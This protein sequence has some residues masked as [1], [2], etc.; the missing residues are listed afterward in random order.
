MK[1]VKN[2]VMYQATTR[3]YKVGDILEFGKERNYQAQR[4]FNTNYRMDGA[5]NGMAEITK[6][7]FEQYCAEHKDEL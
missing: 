7:L 5:E 4:V 3:D 2:L 6:S 1:K